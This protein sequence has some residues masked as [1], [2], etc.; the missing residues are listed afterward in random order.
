MVSIQSPGIQMRGGPQ[1][2]AFLTSIAQAVLTD[3]QAR[4]LPRLSAQLM[5]KYSYS[6]LP[7]PSI[8]TINPEIH[9]VFIDH[10]DNTDTV[11]MVFR[12]AGD[13]TLS[14]QGF[15]PFGADEQN[16]VLMSL[17]VGLYLTLEYD[18]QYRNEWSMQA[19]LKKY[20]E[21]Q[22]DP[23]VLGNDL[24]RFGV[25]VLGYDPQVFQPPYN[26]VLAT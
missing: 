7:C 16:I 25:E 12:K 22:I 20:P 21:L 3:L 11:F 15:F 1:D 6:D 13:Q 19:I 4:N 23:T 2:Q 17:Y 10:N 8:A 5:Y 24:Q 9:A 26:I 18:R 14:Y